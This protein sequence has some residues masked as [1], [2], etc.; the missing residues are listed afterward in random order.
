M[1]GYPWDL[2]FEVVKARFTLLYL[3]VLYY[4]YIATSA[5]YL[6]LVNVSFLSRIS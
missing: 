3:V 2:G 1:A 5:V 4:W 6:R